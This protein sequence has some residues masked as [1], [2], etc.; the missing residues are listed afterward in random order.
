MSFQSSVSF[1][2][3]PQ[4]FGIRNPAPFVSANRQPLAVSPH[5]S[6]FAIGNTG[7][8]IPLG[9]IIANTIAVSPSVAAQA[10][11]MPTAQ[12]I[13]AEFGEGLG[14]PKVQA[15]DIIYLTV[16]NTG[17]VP[18]FIQGGTGYTGAQY[19][20]AYSQNSQTGVAGPANFT[21]AT[22]PL[23]LAQTMGVQFTSVSA[24]AVNNVGGSNVA[25]SQA[26]GTYSMFWV[27]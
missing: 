7:T 25:Y 4:N 5:C 13:L 16:L 2:S 15:G 6:P 1:I 21:G 8:T 10:Y 18:A 9:C 3:P 23:A 19:L 14:A 20:V 24:G 17:S 26:T 22:A 27:A 11:L 12:Q